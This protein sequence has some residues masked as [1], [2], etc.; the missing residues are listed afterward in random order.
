MYYPNTTQ[1]PYKDAAERRFGAWVVFIYGT[2][3]NDGYHVI[4]DAAADLF[5]AFAEH[6]AHYSEIITPS[7]CE[8]ARTSFDCK[9]KQ[10]PFFL[11]LNKHP[12]E[13]RAG[14]AFLVIEWGKWDGRAAI[15]NDVQEL[16]GSFSDGRF[17]ALLDRARRR[18]VHTDL[19]R[20]VQ[21]HAFLEMALGVNLAVEKYP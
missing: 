16:A 20:F 8:N 10:K 21:G 3:S 14:D 19:Q 12:R 11:V 5:A 17:P 18:S 1:I 15:A 13:H 2:K 6:G 4:H 9:A 7:G